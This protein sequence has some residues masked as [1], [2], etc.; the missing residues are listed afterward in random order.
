MKTKNKYMVPVYA[1]LVR[2]GRW[3]IADEDNT[4]NKPVVPELYRED[5]AEYLATREG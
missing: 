3:I 5:V 2:I 1:Y 4:E